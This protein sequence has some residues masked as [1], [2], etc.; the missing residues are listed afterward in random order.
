MSDTRRGRGPRRVMIS[1]LK[2]LTKG[3]SGLTTTT[4]LGAGLDGDVEVGGRH[5]PA[6]DQL[7]LLDAHRRVD[8]RQRGGGPDARG[9]RHVVPARGAEHDA[10]AGVE[11]GGGQVE[12]VLEHAEVVRAVGVAEA[13]CACSSRGRRPCRRREG[14]PSASPR[15]RSMTETSPSWRGQLASQPSA[16]SGQGHALAQ[17]LAHVGPQ[18]VADVDVAERQR[19][20]GRDHAHHLLGRDPVGA[21]GGDEGAGRSPHVDV[22]L[23]HRPVDREQVQRPQRPDLVHPAGEAAAAEHERRLLAP[24]RPGAAPRRARGGGPPRRT[25][26]RSALAG[27]LE[28]DNLAHRRFIVRLARSPFQPCARHRGR[29][30]RRRPWPARPPRSPPPMRP[31]RCALSCSERWRPPA[32]VRAPTS[33]TS[34]PSRTAVRLARGRRAA[35]RLGGEALHLDHR[36]AAPRSRRAPEHHRAGGRIHRTRRASGTGTCTCA[37]GATR[38]SGAATSSRRP[39]AAARAPACP[40]SPASCVAHGDHPGRR[41][42]GRRRVGL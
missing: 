35:A 38:P 17:E 39:T 28:L 22:E 41:P 24:G 29:A 7:A 21:Q 31:P 8:H 6:V 16:L 9:D 30:G 5:D 34:A 18:Q 12:L 25:R 26:R 2:S 15:A 36:A 11:V 4:K 3:T 14:S 27:G 33:M 37:A 20:L 19:T 42:R 40:S 13:P 10:L 32:A 1:L 23:V